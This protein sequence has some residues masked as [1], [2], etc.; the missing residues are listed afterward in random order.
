MN[1]LLDKLVRLLRVIVIALT[2]CLAAD[3]LLQ[4]VGRYFLS[5]PLPWTEELAR[6]LLV[7][8]VTFAAPLAVRDNCFVRVDILVMRLPERGREIALAVLDFV[9][10]AFHVLVA[11]QSVSL[12]RTG[13]LQK[14][15]VLRVP[16]SYLDCCMAVCPTLCALFFTGGGIRRLRNA[17][18]Q[19]AE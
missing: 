10:A 13:M 8:D 4:I 18:T 1:K 3:V 12:L 19:E 7:L 17:S 14:T 15:P 5:R 9:T 16:M 11:V 2:V 6:M